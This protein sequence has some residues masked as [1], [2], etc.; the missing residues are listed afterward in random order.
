M[1]KLLY[2][3]TNETACLQSLAYSDMSEALCES[4][5]REEIDPEN[6]DKNMIKKEFQQFASN[7]RL[8]FL[9]LSK[10]EIYLND[11]EGDHTNLK[12][13]YIT[14]NLNDTKDAAQFA[15]ADM[16][17]SII[18][19]ISLGFEAFL[20]D[21]K[22]I[23]EN[24]AALGKFENNEYLMAIAIEGLLVGGSK[25]GMDALNQWISD[26][27]YW[28]AVASLDFPLDGDIVHAPMP[29]ATKN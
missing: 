10:Y 11:I 23:F 17:G 3:I 14:L 1:P 9:D 20:D 16:K 22:E 15:V 2:V 6:I 7:E 28:P 8:G 25:E 26:A 4:A 5:A 29:S 21:A 24:N 19:E 27:I 18:K 13:V 12:E